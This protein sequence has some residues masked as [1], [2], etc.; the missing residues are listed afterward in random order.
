VPSFVPLPRIVVH[1]ARPPVR[2][3]ARAAFPHRHARIQ[4]VRTAGDLAGA[5][6]AALVDAVL[7]DL[8]SPSDETWRAAGLAREFPSAPF[9]ALTA[10]RTL[11]APVVA[12]CAE[13]DVAD[14]LI[15]GIDDAAL[16][17]LVLP[18]G[19][20]ARFAHALAAPPAALR[21]VSPLQ[22]R[23]WAYV[24]AHAGLPVRTDALARAVGVTREHLSRAF[25]A[26][27]GPPLKR[28]ID[29]VRL[30]A[31]AELAKNPGF[32]LGNVATVLGFTSPSHLSATAQRVLG[33]R[34]PSL[35]RLR[36]V[37]L[38]Q[39]CTRDTGS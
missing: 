36:A 5:V 6:R 30:V 16:S 1:T 23:T 15:D 29:L 18:A 32:D 21:L 34:G 13:L 25:A 14:I 17:A 9:F 28:V 10:L 26:T 2:A 20:R 39:R 4:V 24:V 33:V 7:V 37:D 11:D 12:R 3:L 38:I 31:A 19:F 35:A 27:A 8:A 22:H